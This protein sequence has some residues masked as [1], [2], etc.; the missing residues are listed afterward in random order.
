LFNEEERLWFLNMLDYFRE[1]DKKT[2]DQ[3]Q[4]IMTA[5]HELLTYLQ[6]TTGAKVNDPF[7]QASNLD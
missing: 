3:R 1:I 7:A 4:A 6:K 2:A 5:L